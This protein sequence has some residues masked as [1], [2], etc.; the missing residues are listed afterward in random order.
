MLCKILITLLLLS[1]SSLALSTNDGGQDASVAQPS[2]NTTT[3]YCTVVEKFTDGKP[4]LFDVDNGNVKVVNDQLVLELTQGQS[5][6]V[7]SKRKYDDVFVELNLRMS[8]QSGVVT[9]FILRS[10][11]HSGD[12]VDF[13][14]VGRNSF[15]VQT[16]YAVESVLETSHARWHWNSDDDTGANSYDQSKQPVKLGIKWNKEKIEWLV[17]GRVRREL[18]ARDATSFPTKSMYIQMGLWDGTQTSGW[19]GTVDFAK[20]PFNAYYDSI[21]ITAPCEQE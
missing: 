19:A 12:E 21:S 8:G 17:N 10:E 1:A 15:G 2:N 20:A 14:M 16:T 7:S 18:F 4:D 6:L 9:S 3:K 13:E 5:S 11:K